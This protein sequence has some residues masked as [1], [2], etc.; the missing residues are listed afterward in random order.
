MLISATLSAGVLLVMEYFD[1]AALLLL[2]ENGILKALT[3][4]DTA[5]DLNIEAFLD[6]AGKPPYHRGILITQQRS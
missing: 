5:E 6:S 1:M 2:L 3:D 4:S